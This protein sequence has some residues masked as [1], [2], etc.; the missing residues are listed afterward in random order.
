MN[1]SEYLFKKKEARRK[2]DNEV[3]EI[4]K[5]YVKTNTKAD[6]GD[7]VTDH[8]GTVKVE[9]IT[10]GY[11]FTKDFPEGTYCGP[12][13]TKAGKPFKS[14]ERRSVCDGNIEGVKKP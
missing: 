8:I 2:Y 9:I 12:C 13:Y 4:A 6:V 10:A 3:S 5:E 7:F 1:K 11:G 14:G